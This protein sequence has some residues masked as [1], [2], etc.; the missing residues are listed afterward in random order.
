MNRIDLDS[1][2]CKKG[3]K[4]WS[5]LMKKQQQKRLLNNMVSSVMSKVVKI[6]KDSD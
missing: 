3:L 4:E 2:A 5:L 1:L 6:N